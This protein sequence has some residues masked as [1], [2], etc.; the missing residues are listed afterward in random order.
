MRR[1]CINN[2]HSQI[3]SVTC[4]TPIRR[5]I[6]GHDI[7]CTK[8]ISDIIITTHFIYQNV[9]IC[10]TIINK[11]VVATTFCIQLSCYHEC[12]PRWS[13]QHKGS[14]GSVTINPILATVIVNLE[15]HHA[16]RNGRVLC[17]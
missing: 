16:F 11:Q 17:P 13:R 12:F 15:R 14:I 2:K 1:R 8:Y 4:I 5:K 6:Q 3:E 10:I 7:S 9:S